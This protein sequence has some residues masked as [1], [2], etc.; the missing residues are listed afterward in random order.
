MLNHLRHG[1]GPPL[2][3]QHGFLGGAGYWIPHMAT[4]GRH[5]DVIAPDLP[6]FAGSGHLAAPETVEGFAAA[7]LNLLDELDIERTT[8]LGHSMGSMISLQIALDHPDR[9][10]RLVLYGS[11]CTGN[12]PKRF[13]TTQTSIARIRELGIEACADHIV[14]T[15]F[16]DGE[17]APYFKLCRDAG[18]G[19]DAEGAVRALSALSRWDVGN[20]LGEIHRPVLVICGDRDRSTAPDQSYRLWQGIAGSELCVVPGCAHNVHLERP[21]LFSSVVLDFLLKR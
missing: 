7:L 13:E 8:L 9:I 21:E 17:S 5:F 1:S 20:R 14:P 18:Q 12:L 3:L 15:W 4:F 16:V 19:A 10:E 6:G 2:V 11:A